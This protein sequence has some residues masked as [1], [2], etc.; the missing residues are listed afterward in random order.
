[1]AS[2][3]SEAWAGLGA[4]RRPLALPLQEAAHRGDNIQQGKAVHMC[5]LPQQQCGRESWT[6]N[7]GGDTEEENLRSQR[8]R[9]QA[10]CNA[11][12]SSQISYRRWP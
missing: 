8:G 2:G 12:P 10:G 1:M 9:G 4:G 3:L 6:H 5:Q 11:T 7:K